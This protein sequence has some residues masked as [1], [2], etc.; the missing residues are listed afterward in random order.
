MAKPRDKKKQGKK[1]AVVIE[2]PVVDQQQDIEARRTRL[3]AL[4]VLGKE[5]GYL[6]YAE[7]NDHLPDM[8]EVEQIEGVVSMIN[9]MGISVCDVAPDV[10]TLI[11][12]DTAPAAADEI[13]ITASPDLANL[14]NAKNLIGVLKQSPFGGAGGTIGGG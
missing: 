10:E 14:R 6:T 13:I 8:L 11:M 12:T 3:K 5:R 7:I 1:P 9:D 2:Q 4:I